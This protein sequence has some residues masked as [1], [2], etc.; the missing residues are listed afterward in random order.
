MKAA[1]MTREARAMRCRTTPGR[2]PLG[3]LGMIGLIVATE[4]FVAR[5]IKHVTMPSTLDW[6]AT[7]RSA[8]REAR[9]CALLCFGSSKVKYGVLPAIIE[10]RTGQRGY[11]LSLLSGPPPAAY[12]LL[13]EA[14][15]HGARPSAAIINL[16]HERLMADPRDDG[17]NYPWAYLLTPAE[18]FELAYELRDPV[19][20]ARLILTG[21]LPTVRTRH[22]IRA[23]VLSSLAGRFRSMK[24]PG[25][26]LSRNQRINRGTMLFAKDPAFK[27]IP[28][29]P[30]LKDASANWSCHPVNARYLDRFL[31][32]AGSRGMA[33]YW[34][35]PPVSPGLQTIFDRAHSEERFL[36]FARD[37]TGRHPHVTVVD[38]RHAGYPHTVFTVPSHLDRTGAAA[39]S[40]ALAMVVARDSTRRERRWV[41]LPRY[42]ESPADEGLEDFDQS[43]SVLAVMPGASRGRR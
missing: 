14:I 5:D 22:D 18:S 19:F 21:A 41:D 27:D 33:V 10:G 15:G 42:R 16:D 2:W 25:R 23:A 29:P 32:L 39:L 26:A 8:A 37:V 6:S 34:L 35:L 9:G 12:F 28:V 13:R 31:A 30:V 24:G 20:F 36:R 38:G 1:I 11:N 7:R 43:Q 17:Q 4:T 40:E 3:F